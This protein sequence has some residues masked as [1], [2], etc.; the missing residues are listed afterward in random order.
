MLSFEIT[1]NGEK[2]CSAGIESE[3]GLLTSILSW[4]KRDTS[5]L[6]EVER[7]KVPAEELKLTVGGQVREKDS[8][9][10]NVQWV[11]RYLSIGD[12]ITIRIIE[13]SDIDKPEI[14]SRI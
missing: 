5:Q 9:Q 2:I 1:I 7:V 12:E 13:T 4:A 6:P 8:K 10:I 11:G 14:L 3:F